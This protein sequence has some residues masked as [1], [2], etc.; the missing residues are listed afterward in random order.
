M[1]PERWTVRLAAAAEADFAAILEWTLE[2]FGTGQAAG[3]ETVL[4]EAVKALGD[5]PA[6]PGVS[7]REDIG[8]G[9]CVLHVA[10]N[11]NRGRH[12]L[13]FRV[14]DAQTLDILRILHDSMELPRHL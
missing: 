1:P 9:L 3:Y 10:R 14:A 11:G 6:I 12:F 13:L 4:R 5:G 8:P 2:R 7:R